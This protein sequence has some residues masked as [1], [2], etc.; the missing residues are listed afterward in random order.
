MVELEK[1]SSPYRLPFILRSIIFH[2]KV[3]WVFET[4]SELH[5][6]IFCLLTNAMNIWFGLALSASSLIIICIKVYRYLRLYHNRR[7][8]RKF[9]GRTLTVFKETFLSNKF[10]D[11]IN[12]V[13]HNFYLVLQ[14]WRQGGK[15]PL[16]LSAASLAQKFNCVSKV[17]LDLQLLMF[18]K[19]VNSF[20]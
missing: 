16:S 14:L 5:N 8:I 17:V 2:L 9:P 3:C 10:Q 7:C 11:L 13:S 12:R 4:L 6:L 1:M 20:F 19:K 15:Q 18:W